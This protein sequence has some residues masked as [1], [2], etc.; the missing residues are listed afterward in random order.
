[1]PRALF[2]LFALPI[3]AC[4]F[5]GAISQET[6]SPGPEILAPPASASAIGAT[7]ASATPG[8][9]NV[10]LKGVRTILGSG[11]LGSLRHPR[12]VAAGSAVLAAADT[13][14][15]KIHLS[16]SGGTEW[17]AS[18]TGLAG[19]FDGASTEAQFFYPNGAAVDLDGTV[20][21]VDTDNQAIRR[22]GKDGKVTTIAGD[23]RRGRIDGAALEARF[24]DPT[25]IAVDAQGAIF[26]VEQ[27]G[28][29]IRKVAGGQ[30]TTLVGSAGVG[31]SDG[32]ADSAMLNRPFGL[33]ADAGG[34]LYVADT[35]NHRVRKILPNGF[36]STLAGGDPGFKDGIRTAAQFNFPRGVAVD[37]AGRVYVA[38][39]GNHAI[40]VI[41]T[42][43]EVKTVAGGTAG[44]LDGTLAQA[45]F[46]EPSGLAFYPDDGSLII[47]DTNNHRIRAMNPTSP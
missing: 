20:L 13:R 17:A 25:G 2:L 30:V 8:A 34:N 16:R 5:N 14:N 19:Y 21:V 37:S 28:S 38:D 1:M 45:R 6:P 9:A 42:T 36:V 31:F 4:E 7:T 15:H 46:D 23:T 3:A 43:G 27:G 12:G 26:V 44:F 18:G 22:I 10:A 11:I 32:A 35:D 39:A 47:A 24:A 29:S 33:A 41:E 40:R